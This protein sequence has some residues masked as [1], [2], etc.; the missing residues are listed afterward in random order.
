MGQ[1]E[2]KRECELKYRIQNKLEEIRII[3]KVKNLG[4]QYKSSNLESDYTPDVE[5][6]L[7]K[8]KGLMLRFRILEGTQNDVLLTLKIKGDGKDFQDNYE[9]ETLFSEFDMDKFNQINDKLYEATQ[10]RIPIDIRTLKNIDEIKQY[11]IENSFSQH[12][13]FSQKKRT[14]YVN[15][16]EEK[17]TLDE[18]PSNIGKFL[19]V[20]TATPEELFRII[21]MLELNRENFEKR[22]YGEIIKERQ[23]D[24]SE[25]ER[26]TCIFCNK[27]KSEIEK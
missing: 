8:K 3:E 10:H 20:E 21:K 13:M 22:N 16:Q 19:E 14:E 23:K 6:F 17:I 26:R 12:R 27:G 25:Q 2:G 4:F 5:G 9:I 18:F 24:L 7:C 11:L 15:E 1:V